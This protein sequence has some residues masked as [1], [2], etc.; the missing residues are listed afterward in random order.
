[1]LH[2]HAGQTLQEFHEEINLYFKNKLWCCL[3]FGPDS[4]PRLNLREKTCSILKETTGDFT[5]TRTDSFSAPHPHVLYGFP[6]HHR[7]ATPYPTIMLSLI[8]SLTCLEDTIISNIQMLLHSMS[9]F[10]SDMLAL[11]GQNHIGTLPDYPT[12]DLTT[13]TPPPENSCLPYKILKQ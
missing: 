2:A 9:N 5:R 13:T 12:P 7:S 11:L 4:E 8:P 6:A 10:Y 3:N 1:M